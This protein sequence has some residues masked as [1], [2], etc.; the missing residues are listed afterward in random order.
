[1]SSNEDF[2]KAWTEFHIGEMV[3]DYSCLRKRNVNERSSIDFFLQEWKRSLEREPVP[4]NDA[5]FVHLALIGIYPIGELDEWRGIVGDIAR[6]I[7]RRLPK[8]I[9]DIS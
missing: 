7:V 3:A 5:F 1:M 8:D 6:S 4:L 9:E 2:D